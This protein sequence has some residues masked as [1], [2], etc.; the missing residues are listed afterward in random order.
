MATMG[1]RA[2]VMRA[3]NFI[4]V[5]VCAERQSRSSGVDESDFEI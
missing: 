1:A 5:D 3:E 2:A 4:V